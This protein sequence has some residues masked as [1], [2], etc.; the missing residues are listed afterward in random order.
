MDNVYN[1][2]IVQL[3]KRAFANITHCDDYHK[4]EH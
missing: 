3:H 4:R 2:E 1:P